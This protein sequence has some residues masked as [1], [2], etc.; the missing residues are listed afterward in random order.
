[1]YVTVVSGGS[2]ELAARRHAKN[3]VERAVGEEGRD[4]QNYEV[5]AMV[6]SPANVLAA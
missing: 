5:R 3:G 6:M 1:M 2:I 4:H